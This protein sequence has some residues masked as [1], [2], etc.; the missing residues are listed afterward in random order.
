MQSHFHLMISIYIMTYISTAVT[1]QSNRN[2]Y[3]SMTNYDINATIQ[4]RNLPFPLRPFLTLLMKQRPAR[5]R[6]LLSVH[7]DMAAAGLLRD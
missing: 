5:P 4:N 2:E 7:G 6:L 3:K 1:H